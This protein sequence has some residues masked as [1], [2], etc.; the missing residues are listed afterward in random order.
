MR[1]TPL[2]VLLLAY[3][4]THKTP[5]TPAPLAGSS[6]APATCVE[7]SNSSARPTGFRPNVPHNMDAGMRRIDSLGSLVDT[8]VVRPESLV[9]HVG[10]SID[11]DRVVAIERRRND[12][13]IVPTSPTWIAVGDLSVVQ[14]R[15]AGLMG[16][17]AGRT[18]VVVTIFSNTQALPTHA[19]P[20]CVIVRVL[21]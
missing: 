1:V 3:A 14:F 17:K 9:L 2:P 21:P 7:P 18:Q 12:G 8:I 20:S 15:Q 4:C 19:P 10:E 13:E 11:F 5:S 16:L 6:S